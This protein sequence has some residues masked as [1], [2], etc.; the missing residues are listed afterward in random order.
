MIKLQNLTPDVYSS[1][2]RDFQLLERLF[3]IVLNYVKTNSD[4]L[5]TLP[6]SDNTDEHLIDLMTL[7][8]GFKSRHHYNIKHQHFANIA[9]LPFHL[10]NRFAQNVAKKTMK[11]LSFAKAVALR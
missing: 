10:V 9:A 5:Y 11:M 1:Q 6:L 8:L 2:S 7:T 3:D 4:N